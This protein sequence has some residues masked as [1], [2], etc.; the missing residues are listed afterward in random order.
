MSTHAAVWLANVTGM[1]GSQRPAYCRFGEDSAYRA[2]D[3]F[4]VA[5]R[6]E[7]EAE[8]P[9]DVPEIMFA[10]HNADNRPSGQTCRSMSVGD[11]VVVGETAY[12]CESAGFRALDAAPRGIRQ[13]TFVEYMRGCV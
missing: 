9:E 12:A 7:I 3:K 2:D 13:E 10:R 1:D 6:D 4:V 5:W 8:R 11:V